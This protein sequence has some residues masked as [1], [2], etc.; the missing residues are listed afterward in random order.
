MLTYVWTTANDRAN[1]A[2]LAARLDL[3]F[4]SPEVE[5]LTTFDGSHLDPASAERFSRAFFAE[6][7]RYLV[8]CMSGQSLVAES[9]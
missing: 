3:P 9:Q 4:V 1:A 5:G 7:E 8:P 2:A 6:A